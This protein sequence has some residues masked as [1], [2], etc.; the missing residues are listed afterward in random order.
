MKQNK[1][2]YKLLYEP[3][4]EGVRGMDCIGIFLFVAFWCIIL[5]LVSGFISK[6]TYTAYVDGKHIVV[7]H[8]C[9]MKLKFDTFFRMFNIENCYLSENPEYPTIKYEVTPRDIIK[10]RCKR[11]K[12]YNKCCEECCD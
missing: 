9:K 6:N 12:R 1:L 8:P 2:I 5:L 11:K 3:N 10:E 4:P 7:E